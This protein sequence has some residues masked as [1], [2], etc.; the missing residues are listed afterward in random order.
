MEKSQKANTPKKELVGNFNGGVY[1]VD[2]YFSQTTLRWVV[3]QDPA[4]AKV[5]SSTL[6]YTNVR[7]NNNKFYIMQILERKPSPNTPSYCFFTRFGRNG[8]DGR[9]IEQFLDETDGLDLAIQRFD[10]VFSKKTANGEYKEVKLTTTAT[11]TNPAEEN[12]LSPS[13]DPQNSSPLIG[14]SRS[15]PCTS[16]PTPSKLVKLEPTL[17]FLSDLIFSESIMQKSTESISY[18]AQ[19]MP[20]GKLASST[21][22]NGYRILKSIEDTLILIENPLNNPKKTPFSTLHQ[23][24]ED[25]SSEFYTCIP[26]NLGHS[27]NSPLP[28]IS[29]LSSLSQETQMLSQLASLHQTVIINS[30]ALLT[31]HNL[32][33]QSLSLLPPNTPTHNLISKFINLTQSP[34]HNL[35]FQITAILH[36]TPSP[37]LPQYN[38]KNLQNKTL[39]FHG[40]RVSNFGGILKNGLKIAPIEAPV[41]GYMFGKG[42]YFA[43][44]ASKAM[45]YCCSGVSDGWGLLLVCEVALGRC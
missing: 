29:S 37:T 12:T 35:K 25:Q 7:Q 19:A 39:L 5:Y 43:D 24:I 4:S 11:A 36:I 20:L 34:A 1:P 30:G 21:I 32:I 40:S 42:A 27:L 18:D 15:S 3:Y 8:T 10:Q 44:L 14:Q 26:H 45:N 6:N 13:E 16:G 33:S 2:P 17:K 23:Q 28:R 31:A 41:S 38:P 9:P 22:T